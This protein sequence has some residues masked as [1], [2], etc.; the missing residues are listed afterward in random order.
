M[1]LIEQ[2]LNLISNSFI[3][4]P[5]SVLAG[6]I[7]TGYLT[8]KKHLQ[9]GLII[10]LISCVIRF[11]LFKIKVDPEV[12]AQIGRTEMD[13]LF[14]PSIIMIVVA[15]LGGSLGGLIKNRIKINV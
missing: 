13:L 15:A 6:S 4:S 10:G 1:L 8:D 2:L 11:L 12:L 9:Y 14:R 3:N 7:V 5:L